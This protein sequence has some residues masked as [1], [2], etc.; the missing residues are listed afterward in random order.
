[1]ITLSD[2]KRVIDFILTKE[3]NVESPTVFQFR[4]LSKKAF[5]RLMDGAI[6]NDGTPDVVKI[7]ERASEFLRE[8]LVGIKNVRNP[9]ADAPVDIVEIN[10][11]IIEMIPMEIQQEVATAICTQTMLSEVEQ[12]K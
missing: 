6:N 5:F 11:E 2:P 9:G 3:K 12:K 10:D 4:P 1:M 7:M 8:A